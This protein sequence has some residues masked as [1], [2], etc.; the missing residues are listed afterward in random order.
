MIKLKVWNYEDGRPYLSDLNY[1]RP[2]RYMCGWDFDRIYKYAKNELEWSEIE[3]KNIAAFVFK[4][5]SEHWEQSVANPNFKHIEKV[6]YYYFINAGSTEVD[7]DSKPQ[8]LK[9]SDIV[10]EYDDYELGI[11]FIQLIDNYMEIK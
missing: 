10:Q 5:E 2:R 3:L 7:L 8:G 4:N 11:H 6:V 1:L 9:N